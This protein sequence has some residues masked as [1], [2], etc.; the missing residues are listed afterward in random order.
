MIPPGWLIGMVQSVQQG[1][2]TVKFMH[3]CGGPRKNFSWQPVDNGIWSIP[4]KS[5]SLWFPQL[6]LHEEHTRYQMMNTERHYLH[7]I[8]LSK[9][10]C[11]SCIIGMTQRKYFA[12]K[13]LNP[14]YESKMDN[15][16][17][18]K[19]LKELYLS[20]NYTLST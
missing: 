2:V 14:R 10:I 15:T 5:I 13:S 11:R 9:I 19:M 17:D 6:H 7:M 1:V 3:P 4:F 8:C 20:H 18:D 12:L 16:S